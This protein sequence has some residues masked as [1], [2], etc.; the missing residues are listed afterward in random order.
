MAPGQK[1]AAQKSG[2]DLRVGGRGLA[3]RK[4]LPGLVRA[5]VHRCVQEIVSPQ[6]QWMSAHAGPPSGTIAAV[7]RWIPH[8]QHACVPVDR[9]AAEPLT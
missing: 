7:G 9:I 8:S 3:A 2:Q 5:C 1:L 4:G 6:Y